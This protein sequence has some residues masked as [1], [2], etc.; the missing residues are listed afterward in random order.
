[1]LD[2][3]KTPW[4]IKRRYGQ[5]IVRLLECETCWKNFSPTRKEDA[6]KQFARLLSRYIPL[7]NAPIELLT[8]CVLSFMLKGGVLLS[9]GTTEDAKR[10][11][12]FFVIGENH[13]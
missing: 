5:L 13:A 11:D 3:V 9:G 1:M 8:D 6:R 7:D 2:Q 10:F 4:V 12:K